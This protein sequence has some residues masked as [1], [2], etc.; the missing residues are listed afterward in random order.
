MVLVGWNFELRLKLSTTAFEVA[1][2]IALLPKF[3]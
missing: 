2:T 1:K 3:N